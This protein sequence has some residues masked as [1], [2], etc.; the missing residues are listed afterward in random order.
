MAIHEHLPRIPKPELGEGDGPKPGKLVKD[1]PE[2]R[3]EVRLC[4]MGATSQLD[5]REEYFARNYFGSMT[6]SPLILTKL[7]FVERGYLAPAL[8]C[9][10]PDNQVIEAIIFPEA[11][12]R[13]GSSMLA[14]VC[15]V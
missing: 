2:R 11:L 7:P 15:S 14:A 6:L 4:T 3:A 10:C 1:G 9:R 5:A 8:Q 12:I 13:P